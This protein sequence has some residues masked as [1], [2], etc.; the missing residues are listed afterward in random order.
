[1]KLYQDSYIVGLDMVIECDRGCSVSLSPEQVT[2]VYNYIQKNYVFV[3]NEAVPIDPE[4]KKE[5]ENNAN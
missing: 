5:Q 3:D 4:F 1:M 2:E